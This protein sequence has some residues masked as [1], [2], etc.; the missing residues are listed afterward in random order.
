MRRL[1]CSLSMSYCQFIEVRRLD[2]EYATEKEI[3][4]FVRESQSRKD[5]IFH[6]FGSAVR[7]SEAA[8]SWAKWFVKHQIDVELSDWTSLNHSYDMSFLLCAC[9]SRMISF[10]LMSSN[11]AGQTS[12]GI[13]FAKLMDGGYICQE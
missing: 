1:L 9:G 8:P 5:F 12:Y 11:L 10:N 4:E 6:G 3:E 13:S 7:T 2:P